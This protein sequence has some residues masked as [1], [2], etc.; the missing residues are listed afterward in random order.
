MRFLAISYHHDLSLQE[1]WD[2]LDCIYFS[3]ITL[4]TAGLG[5]FTP[6][7]DSSKLFAI[8]F[9]YIG[10]AMIGLLLGGLLAS[11]MDDISHEKAKIANEQNC[12]NCKRIRAHMQVKEIGVHF[13]NHYG[14]SRTD[15]TFT[16]DLGV[17]RYVHFFKRSIYFDFT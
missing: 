8:V 17:Q 10:V 5:D 6:T 14:T 11:S 15:S 4:T 1:G 2:P 9:I 3:V 16:P 13:G 12:P 7:T